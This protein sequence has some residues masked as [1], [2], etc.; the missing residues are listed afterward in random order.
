MVLSLPSPS[1]LLQDAK[2]DTSPK[3]A[4]LNIPKTWD[5]EEANKQLLW[6]LEKMELSPLQEWAD[7]AFAGSSNYCWSTV[8]DKQDNAAFTMLLTKARISP[9]VRSRNLF[10]LDKA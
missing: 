9:G 10:I 7:L 5:K 6:C 4:F 3:E 1:A 2:Q 8:V